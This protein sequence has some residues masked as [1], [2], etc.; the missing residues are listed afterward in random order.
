MKDQFKSYELKYK[1]IVNRDSWRLKYHL[2][3]PVGWLNDPNGLCQFHGTYHIFYQYSP[4][5]PYGAHKGWGH[6]STKDFITF[7]QEDIPIVPDSDIDKDGAYSGSAFIDYDRI[8]FFYTG[9]IK[10]EGHYDYINEGRGHYVNYF[11]SDDGF[12]FSNKECLL[13]N[14]DYP[15][16]M[17]CHVRDPKIIKKDNQYYLVLGARTKDS[18]GCIMLYKSNDLK[19]WIYDK[20]LTTPYPFGYMWECP[21]LFELDNHT[22]LIT[23]PQG[24]NQD[25]YKYENIYQNGYFFYDNGFSNFHELD[26]G[27]DFYAPQTFEDEKGRRILIGWMGLPDTDYI[28]PTVEYYWQHAL[29]LPRILSIKNNHIYQFPIIETNKLINTEE[30]IFLKKNKTYHYSTHVCHIHFLTPSLFHIKLRKDVI[31]TYDGIILTL[32][33]GESGYGRKDRHIEIDHINEIDIYS[34]TSSLEIFINHGEEVFTTRVYDNLEDT[35]IT[36]D[37]DMTID[38]HTMNSYHIV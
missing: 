37:Q 18:V 8:H 27:F 32:S 3:P 10:F 29:T 21:D 30:H 11:Y 35:N 4:L 38:Y 7:K 22:V 24:V 17:S 25:G 5:S 19:H 9:N 6:Y 2:M 13:K 26:H 34:D 31:L 12:H 16:N 33:L 20:T 36:F 15:D 1:D 28:N 14:E 23:C